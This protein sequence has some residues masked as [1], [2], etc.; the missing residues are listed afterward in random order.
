MAIADD[1]LGEPGFHALHDD[2]F[3]ARASLRR[4]N[5]GKQGAHLLIELAAAG[6]VQRDPARLGLVRDIGRE[7]FRRDRI[8]E[9][10]LVARRT[11]DR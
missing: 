8:G 1:D 9:P 4:R 5:R 7:N 3:D 10:V 6:D 11:G 2:S